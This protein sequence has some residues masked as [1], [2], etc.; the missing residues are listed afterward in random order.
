[1]ELIGVLTFS[2][3][4]VGPQVDFKWILTATIRR[5]DHVSILG[6]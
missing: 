5:I 6:I 3:L 2:L 1:M 4:D